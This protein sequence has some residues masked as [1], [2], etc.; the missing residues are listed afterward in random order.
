MKIVV[1][2][3]GLSTERD[4]SLST[5]SMVSNAL[6][7]KGHQVML[8]DVFMGCGNAGDDLAHLFHDAAEAEIPDI[9][10]PEGPADLTKV[11]AMRKDQSDCFFGINVIELC[12][13]AD[14]VF[15]ALHGENGEDGRIQAAFD[16]FGIRYTGSNYL[17]SAIAMDKKLSKQ[18]F[19]AAGIPTPRSISM[20]RSAYI[21]DF[22]QSGLPLPCIIKPC[23]GGSSVGISVIH[24]PAEYETALQEAFRLEDE[25]IL[26]EY[27]EGREF[28]VAVIESETLPVIEIAPLEG[29]YDY[30]NKYKAGS[31]IETCPA[32]LP[33]DIAGQIQ[34]YAKTAVETLGIS[35]YA[36]ADFMLDSQNRIYCLE[37]NT[38]PGMTPTS[39]LPQEAAA[40]GISFEDLCE[41]LVQIKL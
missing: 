26:E 18:F 35:T 2:A 9:P 4:V 15:L 6:R 8:L 3:G 24:T 28:S 27:I 12:R 39:L 10:V 21:A 13:M 5:G 23:H 29:F 32:D 1:L 41:R 25:V 11:K 33:A 19:A 36:R 31:T 16:L 22:S 38:L 7:R 20:N 37:V 14:I 40:I 34:A 30:K 17:S